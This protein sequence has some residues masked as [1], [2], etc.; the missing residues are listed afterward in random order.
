MSAGGGFFDF[1]KVHN[2]LGKVTNFG[3]SR[4]L[5]S[6]RNGQLKKVW[7]DSAPLA[8]IGLMKFCASSLLYDPWYEVS[9]SRWVV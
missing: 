3:T 6:W 5:F 8:L 9:K 1:L 7:A 4:P 2:E